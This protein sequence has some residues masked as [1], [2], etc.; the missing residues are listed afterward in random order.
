MDDKPSGTG[1]HK[2]ASGDTPEAL[3]YDPMSVGSF[4][5]MSTAPFTPERPLWKRLV[6]RVDLVLL[7]LLIIGAVGLVVNGAIG[8]RNASS[9]SGV[10]ADFGAVQVPLSDYVTAADGV[11][12]DLGSVSV[13]GSLKLNNAVVIAPSV[14]PNTPTAGQLYFD[15]NTNQLAYYSGTQFV[16]LSATQDSTGV[17]SIGGLTGQVTLGGGLNVAGGRLNNTGVL[18]LQGQTG[19]ITLGAGRGIAIAGTTISNTGVISVVSGS[20]SLVVT[21]DGTGNVTVT[22]VGSGS[23]TVTSS[24]GTN[25]TIPLFTGAQNIENSIVTQSGGAITVTGN[26]SATGALTLG[27]ALSVANGGTGTTS[28]TANGVLVGNGVSAVSSVVAGGSGLCLMSTAGTPAFAACP[29]GGGATGSGTNN[30]LAKFTSTG[31]TIGDSTITDDGVTVGI[32][33]ALNVSGAADFATTLAAGTANAF[34]VSAAGAVTAVGVN[35]GTGLLQGTGGLTLT[36]TVLMNDNVNSNVSI[37]TGTSTGT[38]NVG[39]GSAVLSLNTSTIDISAGAITGVTGITMASGNFL[40]NGAGTFGTGSGAVS[41]NGTVTVAATKTLTVTSGLTSLTGNTT[42]DALT[43]SNSTSTGNIALFKDNSTTV[44]TIADGGAVTAQNATDS[45]NAF[46]VLSQGGGELVGADTTDSVVRLLNNHT[47]TVASGGW[48]DDANQLPA[49]RFRHSAVTVNGYMY[50]VGGLDDTVNNAATSTVYYTKVNADG[51]IGAWNSTTALPAARGELSAVTINGYIYAIGGYAGDI[52]T[53]GTLQDTVYYA[54]VN[55]DGTVGAWAQTTQ[56]PLGTI[57]HSSVTTNGYIYVLG[58]Q[59]GGGDSSSVYYAKANADGTVGAWNS[60]TSLPASRRYST[61]SVANGYIYLAGGQVSVV[62]SS[63]IVYAHINANGSIGSWN[64]TTQ[65]LPDVQYHNTSVILNGY[66]YSIGGQTTNTYDVV[67]Y[68][69]I[70]SSGD[71]TTAFSSTTTMNRERRSGTA[72]TLNGRIY[73]IGGENGAPPTKVVEYA[74]PARVSIAGALDLVG[75]DSGNLADGNAGG[76]LTAGNTRIAG[77]LDV[78]GATTFKD[79]LT[80]LNGLTVH[81][82]SDGTA[83]FAVLNASGVPQF[84]I[85]STNARAYVG[86]PTA[87]STGALLVLDTKNTSGD[88]TGVNG[89]MYYNS[90]TNTF[91]CYENSVWTDCLSRHKIV[92]GGDVTDSTGN[93]CTMA[94]VTGLSFAV[95]SGSNYHFHASILYTAAAATTGSKFSVTSPSSPTLLAFSNRSGLTNTTESFSYENTNDGGVCTTD[96]PSTAAQGNIATLE[97][98]IRPSANGTLQLRMGT[99]VDTSAITVK[100]GSTLEW[101]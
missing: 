73:A 50:V 17:S 11:N 68:A 22:N 21:N 84:S 4:G 59:N 67:Y 37:S 75:F 87:D 18:S 1:L 29:G 101:W 72:V 52:S 28:L 6:A 26:L 33:A 65:S 78:S 81:T 45:T 25:G 46:R 12:V 90:A 83:V 96:S 64:T 76:Q 93:A 49:G 23:G 89:S 80:A 85:D 63:S 24:G 74:S 27:T 16:P 94:D 70:S 10:G 47:G 55:P 13:N 98:M 7:V 42:G 30:T 97:G 40:Q 56:L 66:L 38:I 15:Q 41:L 69:P 100:A 43:V 3:S 86:N 8:Q 36:G 14:Q 91:R 51:T 58:G 19:T 62:A 95:A 82:G 92:L 53:P 2:A 99:E 88:P 61:A 60:G 31:S 54:K 35:S 9:T 20:P 77:T 71:I 39:G 32:G 44:L 34:Q 5:D 57:A 48:Q 79:G